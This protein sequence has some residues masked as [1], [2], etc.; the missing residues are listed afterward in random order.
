MFKLV[1]IGLSSEMIS[2]D[3]ATHVSLIGKQDT[4]MS[5]RYLCYSHVGKMFAVQVQLCHSPFFSL[6]IY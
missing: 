6:I 1:Y 2:L 4:V 3:L 5:V